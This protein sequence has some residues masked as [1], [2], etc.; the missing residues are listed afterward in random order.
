MA[1]RTQF[2]I[3][4]ASAEVNTRPEDRCGL[5]PDMFGNGG[6]T[7]VIVWDSKINE[8]QAITYSDNFFGILVFPIVCQI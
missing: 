4:L 6:T 3:K 5:L 2:G 1:S 7:S 8:W